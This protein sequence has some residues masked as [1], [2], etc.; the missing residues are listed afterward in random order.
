MSLNVYCNRSHIECHKLSQKYEVYFVTTGATEP[1][2][3]SFAA[4][5]LW[6]QINFY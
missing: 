6:N 5:F 2:Q 1:N 4:F 3:I